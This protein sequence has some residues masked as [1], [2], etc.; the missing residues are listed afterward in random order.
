MKIIFL[1]L[2]FN[3]ILQLGACHHFFYLFLEIYASSVRAWAHKVF[4]SCLA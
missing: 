2:L 4:N 3:E 1:L